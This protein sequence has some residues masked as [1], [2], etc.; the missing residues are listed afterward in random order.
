MG[1][2]KL[3]LITTFL[4]LVCIISAC[5]GGKV[6]TPVVTEHMESPKPEDTNC[7]SDPQ[8][9]QQSSI[10]MQ[11]SLGNDYLSAELMDNTASLGWA[12]AQ[13]EDNYTFNEYAKEFLPQAQ[14]RRLYL[15]DISARYVPKIN[16]LYQTDLDRKT[17]EQIYKDLLLSPHGEYT[18]F[19]LGFVKNCV[20]RRER[21]SHLLVDEVSSIDIDRDGVDDAISVRKTPAQMHVVTDTGKEIP[22]YTF[23]VIIN[24]CE[25]LSV[26][27]EDAK[28]S[29]LS[30]DTCGILIVQPLG[31]NIGYGLEY[32]SDYGYKAQVYQ[33]ENKAFHLLGLID[34]T[35][36]L[37]I[38]EGRFTTLGNADTFPHND[39]P[40]YEV[41]REYCIKGGKLYQVLH[42]WQFARSIW[43]LKKAL[44]IYQD[45]G[46][47]V[48]DKVIP[49]GS[50]V[51]I[52]S[53]SPDGWLKLVS[54]QNVT[55]WIK[56]TLDEHGS[57]DVYPYAMPGGEAMECY[58]EEYGGVAG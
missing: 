52:I 39:G 12:T 47:A 27:Y 49:D 5:Q 6:F 34:G 3:Q 21:I 24:G 56:M 15:Q 8:Q 38:G 46:A 9:T 32:S 28:L 25:T 36:D 29:Y 22:F 48:S 40:I 45:P 13:P 37:A 58:F 57:W 14:S 2:R 17:L 31:Y 7:I 10:P 4:F 23:S 44:P 42:E 26:D 16:S 35:V 18:E 43:Q 20:E 55:G 11:D 51:I 1:I 53:Y 54:D 41:A 50:F 33:Y 30:L 19:N